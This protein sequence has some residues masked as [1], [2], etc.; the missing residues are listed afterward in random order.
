MNFGDIS[1]SNPPTKVQVDLFT[2]NFSNPLDIVRLSQVMKDEG[3]EEG[4]FS[5]KFDYLLPS[6]TI[7]STQRNPYE[8][9]ESLFKHLH[10][11]PIPSLWNCNASSDSGNSSL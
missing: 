9:S 8:L 6:N 4:S 5:S 11:R 3:F 10:Q 7:P 2:H 1:V